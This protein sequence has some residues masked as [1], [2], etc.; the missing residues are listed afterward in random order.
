MLNAFV[1][2]Q[3]LIFATGT[4]SANALGF[5][6]GSDVVMEANIE[7]TVFLLQSESF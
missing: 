6:T 1:N 3:L 4:A 2:D 5:A 7:S